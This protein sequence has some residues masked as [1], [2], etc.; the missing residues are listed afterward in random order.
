[1]STF[2]TDAKFSNIE[3]SSMTDLLYIGSTPLLKSISDGQY[4]LN[5]STD[6]IL[7]GVNTITASRLSSSSL[8]AFKKKAK[9]FSR[10]DD[11]DGALVDYLPISPHLA[12]RFSR[13]SILG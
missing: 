6:G 2:V 10:H 5:V 4:K 13:F 1:M 12:D 11:Y 7:G 3:L 9:K 8:V